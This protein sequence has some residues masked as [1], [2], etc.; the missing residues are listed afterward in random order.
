MKKQPLVSII[1]NCLNGEKYL[2]ESLQS[3]LNQSYKNWELIFWDNQSND[4]SAKILK[5]YNDKRIRYF[6]SLKKEKLYKARYLAV[7]RSKGEILTFID[8]DDLW[9]KTKL[10]KQ[11]NFFKKNPNSEIVYSNYYVIKKFF[12]FFIK[13]KK[14]SNFLPSGNITN[15]LF[16]NYCVGWPTIAIKKKIFS[17]KKNFFK[18]RLNMIADFELIIRLSLNRKIYSLQEPLAIYRQ[19]P[20]Q[21]TRKNFYDQVNHYLKWYNIIRY[22]KNYNRNYN[23]HKLKSKIIFFKAIIQLK[24]NNSSFR[25]MIK[26]FFKLDFKNFLKLIIFFISPNLYIKYIMGI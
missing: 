14:Y 16:N 18:E 17:L 7:K 4:K 3:V 15:N 23:F 21:L 10:E 2:N 19:H 6:Y 22:K 26:F 1:M 25:D 12:N 11:V 8:V 9:I 20:N 13:K 5:R 24:K